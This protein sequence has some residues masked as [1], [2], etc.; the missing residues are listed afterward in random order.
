MTDF[1]SYE[2]C[3]SNAPENEFVCLIYSWISWLH[4]CSC[5]WAVDLIVW[6]DIMVETSY[7]RTK[8]TWIHTADYK[9][10]VALIKI[11]YGYI[12]SDYTKHFFNFIL[13][14]ILYKNG[15]YISFSDW[16]QI[17]LVAFRWKY[18]WN[19]KKFR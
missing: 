16:L 13:Y 6:H 11:C 9:I 14:N 1:L 2:Q 7:L 15:T 8:N 5:M 18:Q 4:V 17:T 19:F 10:I 3:T 12:I